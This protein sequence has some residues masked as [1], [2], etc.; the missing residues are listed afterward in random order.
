M[1]STTTAN[2]PIS[3][4]LPDTYVNQLLNKPGPIQKP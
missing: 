1:N 3:E 2:A 4:I